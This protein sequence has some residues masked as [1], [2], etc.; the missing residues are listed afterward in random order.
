VAVFAPAFGADFDFNALLHQA[1]DAERDDNIGNYAIEPVVVD[2]IPLPPVSPGPPTTNATQY[3]ATPAASQP[4]PSASIAATT[5]RP[6]RHTPPKAGTAELAYRK[7]KGKARERLK[8]QQRKDAAPY[9]NFA[10]KPHLVNKHLR[11]AEMPIRST[12][13]ANDM[14]H[15]STAYVGKQDSRGA[16]RVFRLEELVGR[17]SKYGFELRKWDGR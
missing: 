13:N 3:P 15:T 10:V 1:I 5:A 11:K 2:G 8:A 16:G 4:A 14:P 17:G 9:G 7:A 6:S 12:F